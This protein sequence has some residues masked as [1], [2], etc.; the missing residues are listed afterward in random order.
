MRKTNITLLV[1]AIMVSP[2]ALANYNGGGWSSGDTENNTN[3]DNLDVSATNMFNTKVYVDKE[4]SFN[5]DATID[6]SFKSS[7]D[8]MLMKDIGNT[9][10]DVEIEDSF[11]TAVLEDNSVWNKSKTYSTDIDIDKYLAESELEGEVTDSEVTYGGA[12]CDSKYGDSGSVHVYQT[13]TMNG[14]FGGASGI[15]V[16][17]QNVGNNS[18]VQQTASTNAALVGK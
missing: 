9:D 17:G 10:K 2:L 16:A 1:A 7:D 6:D 8:F 3:V 4:D 5:H 12:C 13:N 14:A 15:N 18:L 11:N